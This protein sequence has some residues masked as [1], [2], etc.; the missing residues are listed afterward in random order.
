MARTTFRSVG[1]FR[2]HIISVILFFDCPF[3]CPFHSTYFTLVID[4]DVMSVQKLNRVV[5]SF[6]IVIVVVVFALVYVV[7]N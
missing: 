2:F 1:S 6:V 5:R 4:F 3:R 7:S